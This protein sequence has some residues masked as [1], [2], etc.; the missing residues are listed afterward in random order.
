[1]NPRQRRAVLLLGLALLGLIGV[2]ALVAGYVSDVRGEV[3][4][5]VRVLALARDVQPYQAIDD[6]MVK[7][8]E[9]PQRWLPPTAIRD[10]GSLVGLVPVTALRKDSILQDGMLSPPPELAPGQREVAI[11]VDAETGVAGKI[12]RGSTV[13]IIATYPASEDGRIP[14][15]S[16]IVVPGARVIDVGQPSAK[17]G[18]AVSDEQA[19][20]QQVVP[21]TFALS[22]ADQLKV[23]YAESNA[24]EVRLG[25]QRPDEADKVP[26]KRDRVYAPQEP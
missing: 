25:L 8:V 20:P 18:R 17:G 11:L 24:T 1:M 5:K 4:P 6:S 19:D 9:M 15:R 26:P 10:R 16:R 7:E 2:F 22:I 23:T 14:A 12:G 21:V 3:D 13:D